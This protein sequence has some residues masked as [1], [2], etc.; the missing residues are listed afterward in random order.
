MFIHRIHQ[1][2][3]KDGTYLWWVSNP[4]NIWTH[5]AWYGQRSLF[6]G[7]LVDLITLFSGWTSILIFHDILNI[8]LAY[9]GC[10]SSLSRETWPH[11]Y[12]SILTTL[13]SLCY[14]KNSCEY[15]SGVF[16]HN[17]H[18]WGFRMPHKIEGLLW[19][20]PAQDVPFFYT[21]SHLSELQS[22][23]SIISTGFPYI[24]I[25]KYCTTQFN[26]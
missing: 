11:N 8:C 5:R 12:G 1:C 20:G 4:H 23:K 25:F 16:P 19:R 15:S 24:F 6:G 14:H 18:T 7:V 9:H 26:R 17:S 2:A 22:C 10:Q 21:P 13:E 3:G